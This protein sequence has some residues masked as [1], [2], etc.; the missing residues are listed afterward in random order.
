MSSGAERESDLCG[1]QKSTSLG[2]N[3]RESLRMKSGFCVTFCRI[4]REA[5]YKE[6]P[7]GQKSSTSV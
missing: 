3:V 7:E 6:L 1:S 4:V 5:M 2:K